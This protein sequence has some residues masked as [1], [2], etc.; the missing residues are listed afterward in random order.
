MRVDRALKYLW[1]TIDMKATWLLPDWRPIMWFRGFL[2]KPCFKRCGRNLQLASGVTINCSNQVTIGNNVYFAQ[3]CWLNA[4][5]DITIEDEVMFG[6]YSINATGNHT[7]INGSYR[8]GKQHPAP[9]RINFGSWIGAGV[10][11]MSGVTIGKSACCAAGCVV[12][13]DVPDYSVVGG[14]PAKILSIYDNDR[15]EPVKK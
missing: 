14:V 12:T 2:V 8:Y 6:P 4:Y 3:G 10:I 5:G 15:I 11:I 13:A 7:M 1:L 9:V